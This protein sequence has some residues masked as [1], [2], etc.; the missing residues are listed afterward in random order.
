ML[1]TFRR[2]TPE[3]NPCKSDRYRKKNERRHHRPH[4][5]FAPAILKYTSIKETHANF[6]SH[7]AN[8]VKNSTDIANQFCHM[9]IVGC[10]SLY[11]SPGA[12][13]SENTVENGDNHSTLDLST[14]VKGTRE[15]KHTGFT[16][17]RNIHR[18]SY[19]QFFI[20]TTREYKRA[21]TKIV[22][23]AAGMMLPNKISGARVS[24]RNAGSMTGYKSISTAQNLTVSSVLKSA[25]TPIRVCPA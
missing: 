4:K 14:L 10:E 16:H 18:S 24:A 25:C 22:A 20:I 23:I 13:M 2:S 8:L 5:D 9:T 3:Y 17:E 19:P 15:Q 12:I 6:G 7:H 21:K 1:H 11:V